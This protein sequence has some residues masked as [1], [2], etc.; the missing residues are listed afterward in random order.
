MERERI[1]VAEQSNFQ[2]HNWKKKA[3]GEPDEW[4]FESGNH[5]GFYCIDC[6]DYY[7]KHCNETVEKCEGKV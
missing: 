4:G 5:N 3:N 2:T 6:S 1:A 7:C